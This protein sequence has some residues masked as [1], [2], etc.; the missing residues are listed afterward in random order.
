[1]IIF[2][3]LA[4]AWILICHL[5]EISGCTIVIETHFLWFFFEVSIFSLYFLYWELACNWSW[6]T[7]FG[8]LTLA[9]WFEHLQHFDFWFSRNFSFAWF[10]DLNLVALMLLSN[11]FGF[12]MRF[13]VLHR[14]L[15]CSWW[16]DNLWLLVICSEIWATACIL[17]FDLQEIYICMIFISIPFM[18]FSNSC[19]FTLRFSNC[20]F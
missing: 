2:V 14:A 7:I 17:N 19:D 10:W 9:I 11:S 6:V 3:I 5:Q 1:M 13:P 16:H 18:W 8:H 20:N 15:A 12:A 4:S